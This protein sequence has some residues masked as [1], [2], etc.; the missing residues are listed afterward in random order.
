MLNYVSK[1]SPMS[2]QNI[3]LENYYKVF[4]AVPL[5]NSFRYAVAQIPTSW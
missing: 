4:A 3:A 5:N 2:V 1:R